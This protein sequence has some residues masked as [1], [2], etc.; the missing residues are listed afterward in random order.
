MSFRARGIEQGPRS[1]GNTSP[2]TL[3]PLVGRWFRA[4]HCRIRGRSRDVRVRN[5]AVPL[6]WFYND[7][8]VEFLEEFLWNVPAIFNPSSRIG[9]E[10]GGRSSLTVDTSSIAVHG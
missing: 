5:Q 8:F 2:Q 10:S 4:L 9:R 3:F 7:R 1:L 6:A